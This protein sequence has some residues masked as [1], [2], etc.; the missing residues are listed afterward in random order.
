MLS[1]ITSRS[2]RVILESYEHY[3]VPVPS[4][5][6]LNLEQS[7]P[8]RS[9]VSTPDIIVTMDQNQALLPPVSTSLCNVS[10]IEVQ[11]SDAQLE[12]LRDGF[13]LVPY[14]AA[15][16]YSA[17]VPVKQTVRSCSCVVCSWVGW[18]CISV[19]GGYIRKPGIVK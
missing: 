18:S 15:G 8:Q 7:L 2:F 17:R 9:R 13:V 14:H 12:L 11:V 16:G 6:V 19:V 5:E 3:L 4:Q 10:Q 1:D